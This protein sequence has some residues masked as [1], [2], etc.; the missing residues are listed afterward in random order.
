MY[1]MEY[2]CETP[3]FSTLMSHRS[4]CR[5]LD[6]LRQSM[7]SHEI[8]IVSPRSSAR[9]TDLACFGPRLASESET[10]PSGPAE[11]SQNIGGDFKYAL[12]QVSCS[13]GGVPKFLSVLERLEAIRVKFQSVIPVLR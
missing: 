9:S 13:V 8:H 11:R 3:T 4:N 12:N 5:L 6:D 10:R 1:I 7:N 2:S